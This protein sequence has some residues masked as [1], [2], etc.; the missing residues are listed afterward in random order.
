MLRIE[1]SESEYVDDF[2]DACEI[3]ELVRGDVYE[4]KWGIAFYVARWFSERRS[5]IE[6]LV[7]SAPGAPHGSYCSLAF[8]YGADKLQL[9]EP[10]G[11]W[12]DWSPTALPIS[13]RE[14]NSFHIGAR[15]RALDI[16]AFILEAD[17]AIR[18]YAKK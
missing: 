9:V 13:L 17:N 15:D 11:I 6:L 4:G 2:A 3:G 1:E 14:A 8:R 16:A 5:E 18:E 10:A 12:I 7:V